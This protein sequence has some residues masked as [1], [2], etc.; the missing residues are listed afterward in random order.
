MFAVI[1]TVAYEFSTLSAVGKTILLLVLEEAMSAVMILPAK[2][3]GRLEKLALEAG[4]SPQKMLDYVMRD[5]F[6]YTEHFV[7]EVNK[8]IA[9]ADAG[10]LVSHEEAME[11]LHLAIE[12]NSK[13]QKTA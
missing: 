4:V 8:G 7:H 5:G 12:K 1:L 13:K 11:R 2:F 3:S 9:D 6:D 10:R